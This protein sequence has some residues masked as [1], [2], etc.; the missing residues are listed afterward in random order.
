MNSNKP[1]R[2]PTAPSVGLEEEFFLVHPTTGQPMPCADEVVAAARQLGVELQ[3]EITKAQVETNTPPCADM[4]QVREHLLATRSA[5]VAAALHC[6]ARL[7]A[8]GVPVVGP[9][10]QPIADAPRYRRI[11]AEY[12]LL[13]AEHAVCGCHVHVQVPDRETGVQV[14]NHLRPWLPVLLAL[15]ANSAVHQGADTGYAS[16]RSVLAGRWPCAGAPPY[17]TSL[18]HH[19]TV[20]AGMLG[21]GSILDEKMIYWDARLSCHLPT[22]EVRVS[23]VPATVDESALLAGLVRALVIT[24]MRAVRAGD[25]AVAVTGE[26]LRM[27]YWRAAHDGVTGCGVDLVCDRP[28]PA[29]D[30]L[31]RLMRHVRPALAETGELRRTKS[32]ISKVLAHGNGAVRQRRALAAGGTAAD[33]VDSLAQHTLQDWWPDHVA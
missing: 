27:A 8:A 31:R 18:A 22:V 5:A 4:Y 29:V 33:L 6:G 19:D 11:E 3:S 16:W 14:V 1:R 2:F 20:V 32:L 12:G 13:A 24:A 25:D 15:T 30:L 10:R 23:D 7:V 26:S 9:L 17:F 28:V 21:S